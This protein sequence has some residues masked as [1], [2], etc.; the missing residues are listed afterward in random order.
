M[1]QTAQGLAALEAR[2]QQTLDR[3]DR[4][5]ELVR[6]VRAGRIAAAIHGAEVASRVPVDQFFSRENESE[7]D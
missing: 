5:D 2:R 4:N 7:R 1:A 6:E 3:M